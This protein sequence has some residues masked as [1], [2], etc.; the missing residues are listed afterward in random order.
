[1]WKKI[2]KI[3]MEEARRLGDR[4]A[5]EDMDAARDN[6]LKT[7]FTE[8]KPA[9]EKILEMYV[10]MPEQ[11][12]NSS[13]LRD[14]LVSMLREFPNVPRLS[15][16]TDMDS[17]LSNKAMIEDYLKDLEDKYEKR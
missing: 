16:R 4:Y 7:L 3:D 14:S 13:R 12:V 9:V 15:R 2:L 1:M 8:I 11:E 10:N 6:K 5:S 17:K